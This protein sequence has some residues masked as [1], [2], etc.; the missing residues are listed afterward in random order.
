M[1]PKKKVCIIVQQKDVQGGI[2]SVLSRYYGSIIE[3]DYDV[4]YVESYCDGSKF[5]KLFKAIKGYILFYITLKTNTPDLVH[6]HASFGPSF[7]RKMPFVNMAVKRK[8]PVVYHEHGADFDTF[9]I[10]ATDKKKNL[11]FAQFNKMTRFI[12]LSEEWKEKISTIIPSDKIRVINNYSVVKTEKEV[13]GYIDDR[14]NNKTVLFL[15]EIGKR[16]GGFDLPDI[17][18]RVLKRIP[19]ARFIIAGNGKKDE[20]AEIK[21]MI[22]LKYRENVEWP[23]W[24]RYGTKEA[25]LVSSSLFLLPSYQEGMPMS[26]LDAMGYGLPIVSTNVGGIPQIVDTTAIGNGKLCIP[27]DTAAISNAIVFYLSN[28]EAQRAAGRC[29]LSIASKKYSFENHISKVEQVYKEVLG[30]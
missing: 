22:P 18:T 30:E 10:N 15:G 6:I 14:F 3:E 11:I 29:S 12:V 16:K 4:T 9:Y 13:E 17:I 26:I 28:K 1:Y 19:D 5:K 7:Y 2:A 23:G 21:N 20:L 8:I 25:A 24:I 27:G